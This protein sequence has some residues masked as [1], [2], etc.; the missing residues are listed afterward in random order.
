MKKIFT[1]ICLSLLI[2]GCGSTQTP[3]W[4]L[5]SSQ[6]IERFEKN[7]LAGE[8]PPI[9][10]LNFQN[11]VEEIKKSGDLDRLEKA[12]LTRTALQIAVL[13]VPDE[14]DYGKI[15]AV[16]PIPANSNYYIFLTGDAAK[17][18]NDLLPKQYRQFHKALVDGDIVKAGKAIASMEDNPVSRLIASGLAVRHHMESE[19]ILKTAVE[20]ASINGWK[21]ALLT[22]MERMAA[23]YEL[24]G[25]AAKAAAVR[26]HIDLIA[27]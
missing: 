1:T 14:G 18:N 17:V 2:A 4:Y 11:T 3:N 12:W 21:M 8:Q 22:W 15:A 24:S 26:Q 13:K 9:T 20:T 10:E 6:Q 16:Q 27:S 7:F 19:E 25:E 23:F 5:A